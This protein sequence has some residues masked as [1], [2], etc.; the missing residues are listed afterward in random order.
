M[1]KTTT[2]NVLLG[3]I[4]LV[5]ILFF[6][7]QIESQYRDVRYLNNC[8]KDLKANAIRTDD[9][10]AYCAG[11]IRQDPFLFNYSRGEVA[12]YLTNDPTGGQVPGVQPGQNQQPQTPQTEPKK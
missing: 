5:L 1:G 9:H 7:L 10:V 11:L 6:G 8:V 12:K 3:I 2:T 4:A